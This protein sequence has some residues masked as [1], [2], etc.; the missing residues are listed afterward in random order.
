MS[1]ARRKPFRY[2]LRMATSQPASFSKIAAPLFEQFGIGLTLV[3][4]GNCVRWCYADATAVVEQRSENAVAAV[5]MSAPTV[6]AASSQNVCAVYV[7]QCA[8][9]TLSERGVTHMVEDVAAFFSGVREP[10][11]TFVDARRVR[12]GA[13]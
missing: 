5:F 6:D 7:S 11:F 10:R 12:A 1:R 4:E 8:T 2:R 13:A 9:Y 3:R